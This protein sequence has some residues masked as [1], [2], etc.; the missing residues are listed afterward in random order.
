[1]GLAMYH[2]ALGDYDEAIRISRAGLALA[3]QSGQAI[4]AIYRLW[5]ALIEAHLWKREFDEAE[6]LSRQLR[7]ASKL[8]GHRLGLAW[9][10]V[11][12]SLAR[13]LRGTTPALL[14]R[15]VRAADALERVPF[16]FDAAR[17]QRE[18]ARRHVELGDRDAAVR[19]LERACAT[20]ETLGAA[21]ELAGAREQLRALGVRSRLQRTA[22][23]AAH[24][25][26]GAL[27]ERMIEVAR[28][29]ATGKTNKEIGRLLGIS[30]RTV[31][32]TLSEAYKRLKLKNRGQLAE[33]VRR[34]NLMDR[35]RRST[36]VAKP[37]RKRP[38]DSASRRR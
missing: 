15:V 17:L 18:I 1:M 22:Q 36:G 27:T 11:G 35:R 8:I 9:A 30:D 16:V 3:E 31:S 2:N 26:R 14:D 12:E 19:V 21:I 34:G 24:A 25:G 20:F 33:W 13:M 37:A 7:Q 29:A 28:I 4:W 10:E 32:T 38:A 6:S 23:Q 5:P